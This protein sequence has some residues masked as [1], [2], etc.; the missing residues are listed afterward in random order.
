MLHGIESISEETSS[1]SS[2]FSVYGTY[3]TCHVLELEAFLH[4]LSAWE[5]SVASTELQCQILLFDVFF[6]IS[7]CM[8]SSKSIKLKRKKIISHWIMGK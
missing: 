3:V 4:H 6:F 7:L 2:A 8:L 1:L 5:F